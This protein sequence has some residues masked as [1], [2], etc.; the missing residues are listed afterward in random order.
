MASPL[1]GPNATAVAGRLPFVMIRPRANSSSGPVARS[2]GA[3]TTEEACREGSK[4]LK[5]YVDK[6][7]GGG[8][9]TRLEQRD[10]AWWVGYFVGNCVQ[11]PEL[12]A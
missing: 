6:I 8:S 2:G 10:L 1:L 4:R 12:V 5:F 7:N 11:S 3:L 9:L